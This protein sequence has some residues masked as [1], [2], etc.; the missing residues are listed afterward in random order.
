MD[1]DPP[2]TT[3]LHAWSAGHRRAFDDLI[4]LVH[5]ELAK[6]ALRAM[7]RERESHTLEP[8]AL[9]NETY[10][11]LHSLK[12]VSWECRMPFFAFAAR[13]MREILVEHSRKANARKRGGGQARV[14]LGRA[15]PKEEPLSIEILA[16]NQVLEE[17]LRKDPDMH[18]MIEL[19]FFSGLSE[20][21]TAEVM[22]VS[23]S[24]IQREWILARR[25]LAKALG[26][27]QG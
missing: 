17:L 15:D 8:A 10:L 11:R 13:V 24:T 23:R 22:Q 3:L 9:V 16:L 7:A 1:E 4:P 25:Y 26:G 21:E 5:D 18:R 20:E 19:R 2:I 27:K 12:R 6:T 14:T